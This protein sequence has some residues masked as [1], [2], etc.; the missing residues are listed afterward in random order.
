MTDYCKIMGIPVPKL[1]MPETVARIQGVLAERRRELF[2][3]VTLNPEI[4]MS[5]QQDADLRGIVDEADLLTADGIGIVLVSR[6]RRDPLPERVTGCDLLFELLETGSRSGWSFYLLGAD[7]ATNRRAADV[8]RQR[9]P[10]VS[11]VGR[12]HGYFD[13][14]EDERVAADIASETARRA[15]RRRGRPESGALDSCAQG[16]AA[17]ARRR[18]RRRKPRYRGRH[19]QARAGNMA[20]AP[21]GVAVP[22][23]QST[24]AVAPA[25]RFAAVRDQGDLV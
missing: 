6:M 14:S 4:A 24:V 5:C 1:T 17:G 18:R 13:P 21:R 23:A 2:H 16:P 10:G 8:I 20:A 7:E 3:V 19:R 9:Y 12:Q 11:V 15:R 22:A 25:A